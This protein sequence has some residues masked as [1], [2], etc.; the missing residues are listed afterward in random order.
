MEC[1]RFTPSR[2]LPMTEFARLLGLVSALLLIISFA[3]WTNWL[4]GPLLQRLDGQR[5]SNARA[6]GI[7]MKIL[8]AALGLSAVAAVLAVIGWIVQ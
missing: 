7:A 6:A 5:P 2:G 3:I 8:I 4:R 1:L